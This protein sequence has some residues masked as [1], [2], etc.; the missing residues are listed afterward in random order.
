MTFVLGIALGI[1]VGALITYIVC[2]DGD[3]DGWI[4]RC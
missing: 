4:D 1:I 3:I 2:K